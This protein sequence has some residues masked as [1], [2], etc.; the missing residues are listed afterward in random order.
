MGIPKKATRKKEKPQLARQFAV[1]T[2]DS[3]LVL[4]DNS[5]FHDEGC[6]LDG[7]D[8]L[9]WVSWNG[10]HVSQLAGL[11]RSQVE[12]PRLDRRRFIVRFDQKVLASSGQLLV[13]VS[14]R[15]L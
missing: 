9:E 5:L 12:I 11:E 15:H 7:R 14:I 10:N 2:Y 8:V 4:D 13:V 1:V 3:F 6:M